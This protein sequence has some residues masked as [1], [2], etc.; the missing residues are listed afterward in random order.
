MKDIFL[1]GGLF[2]AVGTFLIINDR[3]ST[4]KGCE[5]LSSIISIHDKLEKSRKS[6]IKAKCITVQISQEDT[7]KDQSWLDK[8]RA[9]L[10]EK[11]NEIQRTQL[12][13]YFIDDALENDQS[14]PLPQVT[15]DLALQDYN[16]KTKNMVRSAFG[17][18]ELEQTRK[19]PQVKKWEQDEQ[20]WQQEIDELARQTR[21]N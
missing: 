6:G 19:L 16:V 14:V 10:N 11:Q 3:T 21:R 5:H 8:T 9:F 13:K 15:D 12:S 20:R 17:L 18:D 4:P 7:V 2:F 1:L